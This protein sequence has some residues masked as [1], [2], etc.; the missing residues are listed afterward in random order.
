MAKIVPEK[1]MLTYCAIP[2]EYFLQ[3]DVEVISG[4]YSVK[5]KNRVPGSFVV[6]IP[7]VNIV[8]NGK[9]L[10]SFYTNPAPKKQKMSVDTLDEM[11]KTN[12]LLIDKVERGI[13]EK[14]E[15]QKKKLI[16]MQELELECQY[17]QNSARIDA[18]SVKESEKELE[19]LEKIRIQMMNEKN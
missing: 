5:N 7:L 9:R 6:D 18:E 2:V 4:Q 12:K 10:D 19:M 11:L 17:L 13:L 3:A 1:V 16:R 14:K 15:L 8:K